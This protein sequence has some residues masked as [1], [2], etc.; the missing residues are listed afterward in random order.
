MCVRIYLFISSAVVNSFF[1]REP[2]LPNGQVSIRWVR[3]LIAR[4]MS[5]QERWVLS[6]DMPLIIRLPQERKLM[7]L[8]RKDETLGWEYFWWLSEFTLSLMTH[9]SASYLSRYTYTYTVCCVWCVFELLLCHH[10][11]PM[12]QP[13]EKVLFSFVGHK[14][15]RN[16][17]H[18]K[19]NWN[20][21]FKFQIR[22]WIWIAVANMMQYC[23]MNLNIRKYNKNK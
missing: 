11:I 13:S 21:L 14:E 19:L 5:W 15:W 8:V 7:L 20:C 18:S 22:F 4:L 10:I 12:E 3:T 16:V 17:Q 9:V 2:I 6:F 1:G 23:N